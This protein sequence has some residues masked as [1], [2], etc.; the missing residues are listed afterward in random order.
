M[1]KKY[2]LTQIDKTLGKYWNRSMDRPRMPEKCLFKKLREDAAHIN[3]VTTEKFTALHRGEVH[4]PTKELQRLLDECQAEGL[5]EILVRVEKDYLY[6][7]DGDTAEMTLYLEPDP[8]YQKVF[9][10]DA[11]NEKLREYQKDLEV[12]KRDAAKEIERRK[13]AAEAE[14]RR[15]F[16]RLKKKFETLEN[17]D[18]DD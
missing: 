4:L 8:S 14:E 2:T 1:T 3:P 9:D 13:K 18:T 17:H 6:S 5:T 15:E 10:E 11:Y 7:Y 16:A 12:Y